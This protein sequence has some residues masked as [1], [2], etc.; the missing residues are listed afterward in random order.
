MGGAWGAALVALPL[1]LLCTLGCGFRPGLP[2]DAPSP[3]LLSCAGSAD[4]PSGTSCVAGLCRSQTDPCLVSEAGGWALRVDGSPCGGDAICVQGACVLPRCGDGVVSGVETCDGTPGCRADCTFCGDGTLQADELCDSAQQN[5]DTEPGAC[6]TDCRP[7]RCGDGVTDPGEGCDIGVQNSD[8]VP[9]MCRRNCQKPSCGDGVADRLEECDEGLDNSDDEPDACRTTCIRAFCGDG[10]LDTGEH[11]DEGAQNSDVT[12]DACRTNCTLPQCGDGVRDV[13]E[14]CDHGRQNSDSRSD[15]CRTDCVAARCGDGVVDRGEACDAGS[16][17]SDQQPD[18]CRNDCGLSTC[19]DGVIDTGESCDEGAQN[20]DTRPNACRTTCEPARCGDGTLDLHEECD[21]G[22]AN[23]DTLPDACRVDCARATC[24]DGVLDRD[25][26]CDDGNTNSGDGCRADCRKVE[27]CGDGWIDDAEECD[28]A[29]ENPRDGCAACQQQTWSDSLVV[30]GRIDGGVAKDAILLYPTGVAVDA[31][32]RTYIAD[33]NNDVIRRVDLDGS[34]LTVAGNRIRGFAGDGSYAT[35][36]SLKAPYDVAVDASG[37]IYIADRDNYRVRLVDRDGTIRTIAGNG[38]AYGSGDGGPATDA[39]IG[40]VTG[41]AL[42]GRGRLLIASLH[43]VR[44]VNEQGVIT[45]VA[46]GGTPSDGLGDGRPAIEARLN[47]PRAVAAAA[48]GSL[49]IAEEEANRIRVVQPD[50]T[51][52][53]FAGRGT[54]GK[55]FQGTA[56]LATDVCQPSDVTIDRDGRVLYFDS[57]Y[58]LIRRI[59]ADGRVYTVAGGGTPA[60]GIGEVGA[61][62]DAR[63]EAFGRGME[64]GPDGTLYIVDSRNHRVRQVDAEGHISTLAGGTPPF[65]FLAYPEWA[66][67]RPLTHLSA[68][69]VSPSGE[70]QLADS[71]IHRI[72]RVTPDG[73]IENTAGSGPAG[74]LGDDG[75]ATA[76][77]LHLPRD[78][79]FDAQGGMVIA[80]TYNHRVRYVDVEGTIHTLAGTGTTAQGGAYDGDDQPA[81]EAAL[82]LPHGVAVD[83]IGRV[84]IA[85]TANHRIRRIEV[86]GTI[87]T[88]AGT[89]TA[90]DGAPGD[91]VAC[92]LRNPAGVVVGADQDHLW[93]ADTGNHR[94]RRMSL[95]SG[96]IENVAGTGVAGYSGDDGPALLAKLYEPTSVAIGAEGAILVADSRNR[97]IREITPAGAIRRVA[98]ARNVL[99]GAA[100]GAHGGDGGPALDATFAY[101]VDVSFHGGTWYVADRDDDRSRV[102]KV[103]AQGLI[104]TVAGAVFPEGRG[105]LESA[106]LLEPVA[107]ASAGPGRVFSLGAGLVSLVDEGR[108]MLEYVVGYPDAAPTARG[109]ARF[110]PLLV[111]AHAMV[112]VPAL[113]RLVLPS[114]TE[115]PVAV[116]TLDVDGDGRWEPS[117]EWLHQSTSPGRPSA[118][119]ADA[120]GTVTGLAHQ[121]LT[122]E[123]G[124]ARETLVAVI[125]EQHCVVRL[126]MSGEVMEVLA[127]TCGVPG[128]FPG[129]LSF[130]THAATSPSGA[131]YVSDTGNQRVLRIDASGEVSVV[132]GDGSISSAGEGAPAFLFPVNHPG[133][134]ALDAHGNLYVTSSTTLRMVQNVD[135][136][137]D[138]DGDDRVV[139]L[140][141]G[142]LRE[143]YPESDAYCLRA[144]ALDDNEDIYV[145]DACQGFLVRLRASGP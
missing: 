91:A 52:R 103:D 117:S 106:R 67:T 45:T 72:R 34:I 32:G 57:L 107:L 115:G 9:D 137:A 120:R 145:A 124:D 94:V 134:L 83:D 100:S 30:S 127:G 126:D 125:P 49:Y 116:V 39:G 132:I 114:W 59:D 16:D 82:N 11:C 15:A 22:G 108:G 47:H 130:P 140:F 64:V 5:S 139:T 111:A 58:R 97:L 20:S 102:R 66:D 8:T 35:Q 26:V 76:A 131:I 85:D 104:T 79:V 24:G 27:R 142:G 13:G 51:I 43:L 136:D 61:A 54:T 133:Q 29:N 118:E 99:G 25:E 40:P 17:N 77:N 121:R 80:D 69:A 84:Y 50:G 1:T 44:R 122:D 36:A 46:G 88:L 87:I 48:D 53:T 4:C 2:E 3:P 56:A 73:R 68:V 55:P 144:L 92:A 62:L 105:L 128:Y 10:I 138:A 86:D 129:H 96:I 65:G 7:A 95:S 135:G 41:I 71:G 90:G 119:F 78:F 75:P 113:H 74:A 93:I 141:G 18:A 6:R 81:H 14:E 33:T 28:D 63:L 37:R 42:D 112:V 23:S 60:D 70:L 38:S 21:L 101:P 98:G 143:R 123:R 110:A 89:G 31:I 109:L 12:P 19:G